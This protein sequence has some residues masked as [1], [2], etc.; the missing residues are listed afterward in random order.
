MQRLLWYRLHKLDAHSCT[1]IRDSGLVHDAPLS[2][3]LYISRTH[4]LGALC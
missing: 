1:D 4:S 2:F 3:D